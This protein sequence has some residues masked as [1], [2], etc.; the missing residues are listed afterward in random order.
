MTLLHGKVP[1]TEHKH[2]EV[3]LNKWAW[4]EAS[5]FD[6]FTRWTRRRDHAGFEFN[7][8]VCGICF[9]VDLYD[10]RHW[11]YGHKNWQ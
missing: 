2:F 5:W 9:H 11:D 10:N 8:E 1:F 3:E 6:L 4:A 7:V